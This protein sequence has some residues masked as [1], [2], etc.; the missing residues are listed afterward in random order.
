MNGRARMNRRRAERERG[1]T[2]SSGISSSNSNSTE[3]LTGIIH[4]VA[5]ESVGEIVEGKQ[6]AI[7]V[8]PSSNDDDTDECG[9]ND[10]DIDNAEEK[11]G[12]VV[13]GNLV[14]EEDGKIRTSSGE[15]KESINPRAP[16]SKR[17]V[18]GHLFIQEAVEEVIWVERANNKVAL[19]SLS[20]TTDSGNSSYANEFQS[21]SLLQAS[22]SGLPF[23]SSQLCES[24][25]LIREHCEERSFSDSETYRRSTRAVKIG[26]KTSDHQASLAPDPK[27]LDDLCILCLDAPKNS[28]FVHTQSLHMCCCYKCAVKVWHK[29]KRC[30]VCSSK[31]MKVLKLFVY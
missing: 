7:A 3:D 12:E 10:G 23:I 24:N 29:Q 28:A 11:S 5:K 22:R 30:P 16:F 21:P 6:P 13:D 20:Q 17:G 9:D 18:V 19:D 25:N 27:N 31:I 1:R 8:P 14:K 26:T 4:P 15:N 2:N